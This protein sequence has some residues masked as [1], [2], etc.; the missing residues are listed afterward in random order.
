[1]SLTAEDGGDGDAAAA[2]PASGTDDDDIA[3]TQSDV[4]TKCPVTG[5]F[6]QAVPVSFCTT[7]QRISD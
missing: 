7:L 5:Q 2:A 4:V 3:F 1:M 6:A